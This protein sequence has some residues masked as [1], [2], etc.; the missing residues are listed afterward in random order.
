M[1]ALDVVCELR[2]FHGQ[3]RKVQQDNAMQVTL[4]SLWAKG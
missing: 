3:L 4:D 1:G 2:R